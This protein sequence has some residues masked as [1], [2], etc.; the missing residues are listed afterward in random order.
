MPIYIGITTEERIQ[1]INYRI[2]LVE[3]TYIVNIRSHTK[4]YA[5]QNPL[6]GHKDLPLCPCSVTKGIV[7]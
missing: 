7:L 5:I 6:L 1:N 4:F 2:A 3:R